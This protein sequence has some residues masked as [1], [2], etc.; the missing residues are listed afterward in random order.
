MTLVKSASGV[1]EPT[2]GTG[3]RQRSDR[4]DLIATGCALGL[5]VVAAVI[6]QVLLRNGIQM[7]LN[8]PPLLADQEAHLGPG[9]P[10]AVAL[11]LAGVVHGPRLARRLSWHA[12]L[13]LAYVATLAWTMSLALVDGYQ[14]GWAGRLST[15]DEYLYDLPHISSLGRFI[16]TFTAHIVDFQPGSW[17]IQVSGHPPLATLVFWCLDRAGLRGGGW[18]G[19]F[20][21]VIGSSACLAVAVT[22][23]ALGSSASARRALPFLVFFPGAIWIG[24]SADGLF[25]GVAAWGLAMSVLGVQRR[26]VLGGTIAFGGGVLLGATLYLSYGLALVSV[27]AAALCWLTFRGRPDWLSVVMRWVCVAAGVGLVV[28]AFT[29]AGFNWLEGLRLL[30][31]RYYQGVASQRPYLYFIWANFAALTL[32]AG[33]VAAAG[34]SRS[35]PLTVRGTTQSASPVAVLAAA[36]FLAVTVADITGLSKAETER[37]WLPFAIWMLASL[38]LLPPRAVRWALVVQ[39]TVALLVNHLLVTGW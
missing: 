13:P 29:A 31:I 22:L 23:K 9:T 27:V 11:G 20:V 5:V 8:F 36:A 12:L 26:G 17:T 34:L 7:Q 1:P 3:T 2:A 19:L 32:S 4:R 35:L 15:T 28:I 21:M 18:A 38:A 30:D 6:G 25:A 10:I 16:R 33:P 39:V 24:V 37:I 14:R